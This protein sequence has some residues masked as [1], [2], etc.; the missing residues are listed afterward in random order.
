[1][2]IDGKPPNTEV[3][4]MS[5]NNSNKPQAKQTRDTSVCTEATVV[6]SVKKQSI[7]KQAAT[8]RFQGP[9]FGNRHHQ[10]SVIA[11]RDTRAR[12]LSRIC[13]QFGCIVWTCGRVS[14]AFLR[15]LLCTLLLKWVQ[16]NYS[17][18]KPAEKEREHENTRCC[19]YWVA[20]PNGWR[21]N[22]TVEYESF[23]LVAQLSSLQNKK[24]YSYM[25]EWLVSFGIFRLIWVDFTMLDIVTYWTVPLN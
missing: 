10:M 25:L 11:T 14:R 18:F 19:K 8:L 5:K 3:W 12:S 23:T 24:L 20:P 15:A 21:Q 16:N 13:R 4:C 1:M 17:P 2:V 22:W 6:P 7:D 9:G